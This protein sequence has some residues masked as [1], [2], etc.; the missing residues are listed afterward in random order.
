MN[1]PDTPIPSSPVP[2]E[3]NDPVAGR[4]AVASG[5]V[6]SPLHA[7]LEW[8]DGRRDIYVSGA[9]SHER[10]W[11]EPRRVLSESDGDVAARLLL[12]YIEELRRALIQSR[13]ANCCCSYGATQVA[14]VEQANRVLCF[15]PNT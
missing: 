3:A 9:L 12:S 11:I 5:S 7:A 1:T 15:S 6:F 13:D 2:A 10:R 14:A 4:C 8:A